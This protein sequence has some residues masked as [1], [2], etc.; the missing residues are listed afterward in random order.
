MG[1]KQY[2]QTK[3]AV[4]VVLIDTTNKILMMKRQNTGFH[5]GE[6]GLPSGHLEPDEVLSDAARREAFEEANLKPLGLKF[7]HLMHR[8]AEPNDDDY[9]DVFYK[10]ISYEY[11]GEGHIFNKEP[12]KCSEVAWLDFNNL[13]ENTIPYIRTALEYIRNDVAYSEIGW[14][15][16][17]G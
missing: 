9:V 13:P 3:A 6:W 7:V 17:S 10:V 12:H 1:K 8:K 15:A 2:Y 4:Y 16:S 14:D 11:E 5:D